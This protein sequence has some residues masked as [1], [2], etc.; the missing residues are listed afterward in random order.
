[1]KRADVQTLKQ[2]AL[3]GGVHD[4][5]PLSTTE[6]AARLGLSQQAA[7][8]RILDLVEQGL[9]ERDM[10][11]RKQR[12]R[13]T[14]EGLETLRH[15]HAD[16]LR[17]FEVEDRLTIHGTVFTGLGEGAFYMSQEGYVRQ[18]QDKLWFKPWPGTLNLKVAGRDLTLLQVL[19]GTEG[20]LI[21]GFE[22]EGRT[23]GAVKAW[24]ASI[25]A[26]E[27]AAIMPVRTH[28]TDVLEVISKDYLRDAVG[29]ADGDGVELDVRL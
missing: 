1:M 19:Q 29:L 23:F 18:F 11:R 12:I 24:F 6:M 22:S 20:L 10:R 15:E 27:C 5:V 17:I 25:G 3:L 16:Y 14:K 7:S 28:Y 26:V 9:V 13:L 21:E 4:L 8:K 2:I